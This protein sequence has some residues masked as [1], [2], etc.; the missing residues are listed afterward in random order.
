MADRTAGANNDLL[1]KDV[2]A[3]AGTSFASA[4]VAVDDA[5]QLTPVATEV[6]NVAAQAITAG[7]AVDLWTPAAGKRWRLLA[8]HLSLSVAGSVIVKN[9]HSGVYTEQLRTPLL[10][11]GI[12]QA[13]PPMGRG[14]VSP[15][16]NDLLALDVTATGSVSGYLLGREE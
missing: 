16:A 9:K 1:Q 2:S 13:S 6:F 8:Y 11:A 14:I 5:G 10:A 12:G 4:S 15:N 3:G 7:T